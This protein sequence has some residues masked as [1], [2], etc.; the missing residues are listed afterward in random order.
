MVYK[1]I[2]LTKQIIIIRKYTNQTIKPLRSNTV[3]V[4]IIE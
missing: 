3:N 2:Q 1:T 4:T